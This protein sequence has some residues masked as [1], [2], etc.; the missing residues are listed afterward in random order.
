MQGLWWQTPALV[1]ELQHSLDLV[2]DGRL[3]GKGRELAA[4]REYSGS[5]GYLSATLPGTFPRRDG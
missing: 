5:L 1:H 3:A 2:N 4:R